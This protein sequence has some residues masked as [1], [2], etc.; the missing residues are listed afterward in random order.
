MYPGTLRNFYTITYSRHAISI[1]TLSL[2]IIGAVHKRSVVFSSVPVIGLFGYIISLT[3]GVYCASMIWFLLAGSA[4]TKAGQKIKQQF[5]ADFKLDGQRDWSQVVSNCGVVT[6]LCIGT[7]ATVGHGEF[8]VDFLH[9]SLNLSLS[10]IPALGLSSP[11]SLLASYIHLS[12]LGAAAC[13]SADTFASEIAPLFSKQLP[14]LIT[15]PWLRVPIGT[16]GGVTILGFFFS[17]LGGAFQGLV[18]FIFT[19]FLCS[20]PTI[21]YSLLI[22]TQWPLIPF[23][24]FAGFMGSSIDS[25]LGA[26]VQFSGIVSTTNQI[27]EEPGPNVKHIS[28]VPLLDNNLVNFLSSILTAILIL[29]VASFLLS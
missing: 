26:T 14:V 29:P 2:V 28:G 7:I 3:S 11:G 20:S 18:H 16:N 15:K 19:V 5:E 24:M 12:I 6:L 27:T 10:G 4:V 1:I 22:T 25:F 13:C 9:V 21:P 17:I 23:G 8:P